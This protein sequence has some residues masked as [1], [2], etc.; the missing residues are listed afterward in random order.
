MILSDN[1]AQN[2]N[3]PHVIQCM[4]C[5]VSHHHHHHHHQ[6]LFKNMKSYHKNALPRSRVKN[7]K[8]INQLHV[9]LPEYINYIS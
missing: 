2:A 9:Y 1:L 5:M 6:S 4:S 8:R 7:Y 3:S